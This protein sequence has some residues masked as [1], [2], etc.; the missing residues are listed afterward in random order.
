MA[1]RIQLQDPLLSFC[2]YCRFFAQSVEKRS[3][4]VFDIILVYLLLQEVPPIWYTAISFRLV[5]LVQW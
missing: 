2:W 3:L 5:L 4:D 1:K